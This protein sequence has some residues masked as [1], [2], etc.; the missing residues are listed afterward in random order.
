MRFR[1]LWAALVLYMLAF[2]VTAAT[3][4]AKR[5]YWPLY[6]PLAVS[7]VAGFAIHRRG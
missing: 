2:A 1:L 6:V 5:L 7:A 4:P 3:S